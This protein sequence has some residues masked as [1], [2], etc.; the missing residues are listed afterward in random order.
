MVCL[1]N[2]LPLSIN[3]LLFMSI[4]VILT[5]KLTIVG[6]DLGLF[7]INTKSIPHF[8]S[9][10]LHNDSTVTF[11]LLTFA[12]VFLTTSKVGVRWGISV[13]TF[14]FQL[15]IGMM[16]RWNHV[17]TDNGWNMVLES[18]MIIVVMSYTLLVG[19]FFQRMASKEGWIR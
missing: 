6:F 9:M 3:L 15:F 14:L 18:V 7:Q 13:Y 8:L 12:N 2:K 1:P 19:T 10:I 11:I 16:L 4:E 5:N 17:L